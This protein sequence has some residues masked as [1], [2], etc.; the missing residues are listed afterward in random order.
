MISLASRNSVILSFLLL[1]NQ[2]SSI[3]LLKKNS[4]LQK[5]AILSLFTSK[6]TTSS[7]F[8]SKKT[9]S[10]K[11]SDPLSFYFQKN[12]GGY[13]NQRSSLFYFQKSSIPQNQR[14][15]LFLLPKG[16]IL[17][18]FTSKNTAMGMV[19]LL[20]KKNKAFGWKHYLSKNGT[21]SPF[22]KTF[23]MASGTSVRGTVCLTLVRKGFKCFN[24]YSID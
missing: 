1:K 7:L 9:A 11:I 17:S 10:P 2:R 16:S 21:P 14:S 13:S 15:S 18:L 22:V 4:I 5:S 19:K 20:V 23:G 3:F 6:N 8:T 24:F 12:S